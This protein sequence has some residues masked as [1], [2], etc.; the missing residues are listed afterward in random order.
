MISGQVCHEGGTADQHSKP[1][2]ITSQLST[3]HN[4]ALQY[5]T[6]QYNKVQ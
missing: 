5:S 1:Q 6:V 4:S 2:Y 3:V